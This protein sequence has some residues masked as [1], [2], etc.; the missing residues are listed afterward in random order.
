MLF[1][2]KLIVLDSVI[3]YHDLSL[4]GSG[5]ML[6]E[7][8]YIFR[9]VGGVERP[10]SLPSL[11]ITKGS[12]INRRAEEL[13]ETAPK[14]ASSVLWHL[15]NSNNTPVPCYKILTLVRF[16]IGVVADKISSAIH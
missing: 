6:G 11:S 2:T 13:R 16:V 8:S 3:R 4:N 10:T 14:G 15:L 5:W 1:K 7:K 12:L 9:R